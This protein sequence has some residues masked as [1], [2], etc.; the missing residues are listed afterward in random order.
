MNIGDNKKRTIMYYKE[1][2]VDDTSTKQLMYRP[3]RDKLDKRYVYWR[4]VYD[5]L[6]TKLCDT[7]QQRYEGEYEL[8]T[9]HNVTLSVILTA[10]HSCMPYIFF[11]GTNRIY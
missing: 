4:W 7:S 9:Q 2:L 5:L 1:N 3:S 8:Y 10:S 11:F 6:E